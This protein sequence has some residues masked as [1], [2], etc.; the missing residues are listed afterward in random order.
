MTKTVPN[1]SRRLALLFVL[2]MCWYERVAESFY[3]CHSFRNNN[4]IIDHFQTLLSL[5]LLLCSTRHFTNPKLT[6]FKSAQLW[7]IFKK[8][9]KNW[10]SEG[11]L[12]PAWTIEKQRWL[13]DLSLSLS[14]WRGWMERFSTQLNSNG[15]LLNEDW[16]IIIKR[17]FLLFCIQKT[18]FV[19]ARRP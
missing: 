9:V 18:I 13:M 15:S 17:C 19:F 6:Q 14:R 4:F 7:H 5:V 11:I 8:C 10:G 12:H 2:K 1:P 16:I 3:T